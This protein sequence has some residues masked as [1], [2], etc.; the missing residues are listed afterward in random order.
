MAAYRSTVTAPRPSMR[1]YKFPYCY[2]VSTK[3]AGE[4]CP[5]GQFTHAHLHLPQGVFPFKNFA[6]RAVSAADFYAADGGGVVT[7]EMEGFVGRVGGERD[8]MFG[9]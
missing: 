7:F 3:N 5:C 8:G 4:I 1:H 6:Q 9:R 2:P